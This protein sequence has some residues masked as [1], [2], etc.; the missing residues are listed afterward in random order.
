[1]RVLLFD[2]VVVAPTRAERAYEP[3]SKRTQQ[4][5][6]VS[7]WGLSHVGFPNGHPM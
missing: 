2:N 5:D 1:M 4:P 7:R 6:G 3:K